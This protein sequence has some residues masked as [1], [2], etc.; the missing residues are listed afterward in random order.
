MSKVFLFAYGTIQPGHWN[1]REDLVAG[2]TF[3][4]TVAGRLYFASPGSY[5]VAK[6]VEWPNEVTEPQKVV[7][8][9]WMAVETES[10]AYQSIARMEI[11]TGYRVVTVHDTKLDVVGV[12]FDYKHRVSRKLEIPD[13]DWAKAQEAFDYDAY[14]QNECGGDP[15]DNG[16]DFENSSEDA[17]TD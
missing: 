13:G 15:D 6:L 11:N 8:G 3:P 14:L 2:E 5:P 12:A 9:T 10:F 7:H 16:E 4:G 1:F 17:L